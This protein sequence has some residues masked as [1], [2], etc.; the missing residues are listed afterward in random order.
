MGELTELCA[1]CTDSAV[2]IPLERGGVNTHILPRDLPLKGYVG[3]VSCFAA[4]IAE[5]DAETRGKQ[6]G[7]VLLAKCAGNP[8]EGGGG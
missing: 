8:F 5:N 3:H 7:A 1:M 6:K 2:S 4:D